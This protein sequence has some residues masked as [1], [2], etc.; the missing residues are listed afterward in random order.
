MRHLFR[1]EGLR[2]TAVPFSYVPDALGQWFP[3]LVPGPSSPAAP[4]NLTAMQN[5]APHPR[6]TNQKQ[7]QGTGSLFEHTLLVFL[8]HAQV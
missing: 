6:Y 4:G 5:L 2:E 1:V 7:R 8:I 3:E